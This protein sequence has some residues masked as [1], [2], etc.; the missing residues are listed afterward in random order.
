[1]VRGGSNDTN[2]PDITSDPL[3]DGRVAP[4]S[5]LDFGTGNALDRPAFGA[6]AASQAAQKGLWV[7]DQL[8]ARDPGDGT[9]KAVPG[10]ANGILVQGQ[11]SHDGP[12]G[13]TRP[14][15]IAGK[16]RASQPPAVSADGDQT[17]AWFGP[18]GELVIGTASGLNSD[19]LTPTAVTDIV[20]GVR[21]LAV[22]SWL[23]NGTTADRQRGN[24]EIAAIP[25]AVRSAT[26]TTAN[27]TNYN[28][29]GGIIRVLVTV[30][31]TGTLQ[32]SLRDMMTGNFL[33]HIFA[34]FTGSDSWTVYPGVFEDIK[35]ASKLWPR[36]WALN[37]IH[38]D[39]SNWTYKADVTLIL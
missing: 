15:R 11:T 19:G 4:I 6:P 12:V 13:S 18:H 29:R 33:C 37:V 5:R 31:G 21:P 27:F 25:S 16:S 39:A 17:D 28:H 35:R 8:L 1:V 36:T 9:W 38:S 24:E 34:T 23:S 3:A 2:L 10:D 32:M 20:A 26:W 22:A 7:N 30:A 14:V